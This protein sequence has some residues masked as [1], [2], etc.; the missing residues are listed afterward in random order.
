[1]VDA[2]LY[3]LD[4][5]VSGQYGFVRVGGALS[6]GLMDW[7]F[8]DM[9]EKVFVHHEL[10]GEEMRIWSPMDMHG[11]EMKMRGSIRSSHCHLLHR[12]KPLEGFTS[13]HPG[14]LLLLPLWDTSIGK[15]SMV[16]MLMKL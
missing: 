4:W 3:F 12:H 1:M 7:S 14:N 16:L 2:G 13:S 10:K 9:S 15:F 5:D 6:W 11:K 8:C